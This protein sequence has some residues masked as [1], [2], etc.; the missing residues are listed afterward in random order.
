MKKVAC[1]EALS[2]VAYELQSSDPAQR[3]DLI[4]RKMSLEDSLRTLTDLMQNEVRERSGSSF[5]GGGGPPRAGSQVMPTV[6]EE[7]EEAF[8]SLPNG[9][10]F[11]LRQ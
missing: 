10:P 4:R 8:T 5:G 2:Q 7:G 6:S 11:T 1:E 9:S 3:E